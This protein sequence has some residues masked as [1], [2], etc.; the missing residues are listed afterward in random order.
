MRTMETPA[1]SDGQ[2]LDTVD[3]DRLLSVRLL[4]ARFGEMDNAGW[5]NT[6]GMLGRLGEVAL[7]RGFPRT[8]SFAQAGVVFAVA[9]QRCREVFDPPGSM[10][11][12]TMPPEVE[13]RFASRWNDWLDDL[14]AW[15]SFFAKL[16]GVEGTDLLAVARDLDLATDQEIEEI[17]KLKRS[18]ENR[19]VPLSGVHRPT[20][21]IV[22]QLALGFFRGEPGNPAIPY[23]RLEE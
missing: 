14:D 16:Q 15:S 22:T 20:D 8:H 5:W 21:S 9:R 7:R 17:R 4:V 3:L 10:T 12:W 1:V 6:N 2:R 13:D 19:A 11:L 23:A 18:A